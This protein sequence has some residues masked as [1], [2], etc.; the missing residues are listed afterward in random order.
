MTLAGVIPVLLANGASAEGNPSNHPESWIEWFWASSHWVVTILLLGIIFT[1]V[2]QYIRLRNP[3]EMIISLQDLRSKKNNS[4]PN[5]QTIKNQAVTEIFAAELRR[6]FN[7]HELA[8]DYCTQYFRDQDIASSNTC[9]DITNIWSRIDIQ[10]ITSQ[11]FSKLQLTT[12]IFQHDLGEIKTQTGPVSANIPIAVLTD[13]FRK[14]DKKNI[15][16]TGSVQE[17]GKAFMVVLQLL[18]GHHAWAWVLDDPTSKDTEGHDSL[19]DVIRDGA[20]RVANR[21]VGQDS[22]LIDALPGNHFLRYTELLSDFISYL[23]S[24]LEAAK[25]RGRI[26]KENGYLQLKKDLACFIEDEEDDLRTYYLAYIMGLLAIR[27][28]EYKDALFYLDHA[29]RIEQ[30]VVSTIIAAGLEPKNVKWSRE[31]YHGHSRPGGQNRKVSSLDKMRAKKLIVMLPNV[32]STLG[33][34]IERVWLDTPSENQFLASKQNQSD[35]ICQ[36]LTESARK[37][38]WNPDQQS[39]RIRTLGLE[40]AER[41]H[42]RASLYDPKNPLFLSNRAEILMKLADHQQPKDQCLELRLHFR[43]LSQRLLRQACTFRQHP[44]VKY[45]YLRN[46]HHALS[47]GD[48]VLSVNSYKAAL[49]VDPSFIVAARNLASGY[50]IMGHYDKAIKVCDDALGLLGQNGSQLYIPKIMHGWIHNCKG[51]AYFL[52]ARERRL[53]LQRQ[54]WMGQ[55]SGSRVPIKDPECHLWLHYSQSELVEARNILMPFDSHAVPTF[56][57]VLNGIER[58]FLGRIT[59]EQSESVKSECRT[60]QM[61][62]RKNIIA[63]IYAEIMNQK[64]GFD[65]LIEKLWERNEL[66]PLEYFGILRDIQIVIDYLKE[67]SHS[68]SAM[69]RQS[70]LQYLAQSHSDAQSSL[71][72]IE[73]KG[74]YQRIHRHISENSETKNDELAQSLGQAVKKIESVLP[75]CFL[76]LLYLWYKDRELAIRCWKNRRDELQKQNQP[77]QDSDRHTATGLNHALWTYL[78]LGLL[79]IL[80]EERLEKGESLTLDHQLKGA[81]DQ[82]KRMMRE[83]TYPRFVLRERKKD[84]KTTSVVKYV[85]NLLEE[86]NDIAAVMESMGTDILS[87]NE[88]VL[89]KELF[90]PVLSLR[91]QV[92]DANQTAAVIQ[93]CGRVRR[94][95]LK[96][97]DV[98]HIGIGSPANDEI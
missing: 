86:A 84:P 23:Q 15:F 79:K 91:Q 80:G 94:R 43:R 67:Q 42:H 33:F 37:Q 27:E 26:K 25:E 41:A 11:D 75:S 13:F 56:N 74:G 30:F 76:G 1:L 48:L 87:R 60:L 45:A 4:D 7:I 66:I 22:I 64:T 78:Y 5:E 96:R 34:V 8:I 58:E 40:D 71:K 52:K 54:R 69:N 97:L 95:A 59:Q 53:H 51:W 82:M 20:R 10:A 36:A 12:N 98:I 44:S 65:S 38:A 16:I 29:N 55:D 28:K 73:E 31:I 2:L 3:R 50:T 24:D 57:L 63:M 46:G 81:Q 6:V 70:V 21:I 18:K 47:R 14:R 62:R 88:K 61:L 83:Y 49:A 72:T 77:I 35:K 17:K 92:I 85:C 68:A 93:A 19:P 39:A 9:A 32:N 89:L 90:Q